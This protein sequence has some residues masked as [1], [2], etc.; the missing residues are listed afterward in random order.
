MPSRW[1]TL[2]SYAAW[3]LTCDTLHAHTQVLGKLA[4]ALA[5]REP[6][7][8]HF[9]LR[10]SVRGWET[11]P[12]PA[13]DGSG[14]L[15]VALDL[16]SHEA[17]VEHSDGRAGHIALTP[18]RPVG[19]VT[20]DLLA[21]V[22]ALA[23]GPVAIDPTPNEVPWTVPLDEDR[24]HAHY[25]TD[26]V[27]SYFAAA[28]RAAGLLAAFRAPYAGKSTPVNAWWG[29]FDLSVSL[30]SGPAPD[31][32]ELEL[33]VGWWPGDGSY[34]SPAFYAYAA[35]AP[36]G[37]PGA[38]LEPPAAR[39][40]ATLGEF[41]LDWDD[42]RASGNPPGAVLGFARAVLRATCARSAWDPK[43]AASADG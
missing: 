27:A 29:S 37:L 20:R 6:R 38:V 21:V 41:L 30:F 34:G 12:L 7:F 3:Q 17:V 10:L 35:P 32:T 22:G 8:G 24:V 40:D 4:G 13:P 19:D 16:H 26:D 11:R 28:T 2:Q 36:E 5:P 39:W 23:G 33:A 15:V 9:A 14:A 31:G 1:P 25:D 18:H 43:L 42:V